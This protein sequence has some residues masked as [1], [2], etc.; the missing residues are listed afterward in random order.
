MP[1]WGTIAMMG[2]AAASYAVVTPL[3][4]MASQSHVSV[5]WLTIFQFPISIVFFLTATLIQ[6]RQLRPPLRREWRS[7]GLVGAA[8]AGTAIVYYQSL[9]HLPASLAI[10]MLFQFAWML[11][12]ISWII[13]GVRPGKNQW[14]AIATI[15][16][17]TGAAAGAQGLQHVSVFGMG[18]GLSAGL[19]YALTLFW[20]TR[21][22]V[23]VTPWQ[24]SLVSTTVAGVLVTLV[25][26]PSHFFQIP[27]TSRAIIYGSLAG[28]VGSSLPMILTYIAAPR[29]GAV[30][31]AIVASLELPVAVFLAA[32][33][34]DEPVGWVQWLGVAIML[35][36]IIVGTRATSP[37]SQARA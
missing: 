5:V 36:A 18:L 9:R 28:I 35:A 12:L 3:V 27:L 10:I 16:A 20:Q 25:Y 31:T 7:M 14:I 23:S 19:A 1:R 30:L 17:G 33:W 2:A 8:A 26:L 22:V 34:L 29:L 15:V 4:K 13:D 21:Q 37:A 6:T 32:V 11:P 24:Q